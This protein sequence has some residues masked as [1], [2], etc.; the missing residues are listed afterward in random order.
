MESSKSSL[1]SFASALLEKVAAETRRSVIDANSRLPMASDAEAASFLMSLS[2]LA[3]QQAQ[4]FVQNFSPMLT[5]QGRYSNPD[6]QQSPGHTGVTPLRGTPIMKRKGSQQFY[7]TQDS[8]P[9][10]KRARIEAPQHHQL[11]SN[12]RVTQAALGKSYERKDEQQ[13]LVEP[14]DDGEDKVTKSF[15]DVRDDEYAAAPKQKNEADGKTDPFV[16]ECEAVQR[17]MNAAF[18]KATVDLR[19]LVKRTMKLENAVYDY[20]QY[21]AASLKATLVSVLDSSKEMLCREL[22]L[23]EMP[24]LKPK[25]QKKKGKKDK[26]N[27]Q[28]QEGQIGRMHVD[29]VGDDFKQ[30]STKTRRYD[31]HNAS[32]SG[33]L[34]KLETALKG[35]FELDGLNSQGFTPLFV[36]SRAGHEHIVE[37]LLKAK[38][39]PNI[40]CGAMAV[41]PIHE[42]AKRN[43]LKVLRQLLK[44]GADKDKRCNRQKRAVD[45]PVNLDTWGILEGDMSDHE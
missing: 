15:D 19:T 11:Y 31:L 25:I 12:A 33:N 13:D 43:H 27:R 16:E 44:Y 42:A 45:Y 9:T 24:P 36:A 6:S 18:I 4:T 37:A 2:E 30:K 22:E 7:S 41:P 8:D 17:E 28:K 26:H 1:G 39:G 20:T 35:D 21:P 3:Q 10:G 5:P 38:A 32:H 29:S 23:C 34:K 40:T 14:D